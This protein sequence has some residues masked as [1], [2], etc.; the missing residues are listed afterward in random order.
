MGTLVLQYEVFRP[1]IFS[2]N[3]SGKINILG[4][5]SWD[6]GIREI[7]KKISFPLMFDQTMIIDRS[8]KTKELPYVLIDPQKEVVWRH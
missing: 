1:I 6:D 5:C 3:L 7:K 2:K 4:I 8:F